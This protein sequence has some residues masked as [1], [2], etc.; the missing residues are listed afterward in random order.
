MTYREPRWLLSMKPPSP[1]API[2]ASLLV[3]YT[4]SR[5]PKKPSRPSWSSGDCLLKAH[6]IA[7]LPS[8][9]A[10]SGADVPVDVS[11]A[12]DSDYLHSRGSLSEGFGKRDP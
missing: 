9:V 7:D 3:Q 5:L 11:I 1:P 2:R 8:L 12:T 4:L 10:Q 6:A